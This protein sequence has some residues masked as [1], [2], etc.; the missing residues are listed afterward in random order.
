MIIKLSENFKDTLQK[1]TK[2]YLL[3]IYTASCGTCQQVM[4]F[5]EQVE[6]EYGNKYAFYKIDVKETPIVGQEYD[7]K[8][9]PNLL[10]IKESKIKNKHH[11]Y[12]TKE[13]IIKKLTESF[14]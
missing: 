3:E 6:A 14:E 10:F 13:Y 7:V 5:V 2:P 1:E 9:V 4:P 12:I 11:G 8:S